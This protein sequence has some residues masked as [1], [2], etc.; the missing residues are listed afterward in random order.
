MKFIS[1]L[2]H[3]G[4]NTQADCVCMPCNRKRR[5]VQPEKP[6]KRVRPEIDNDQT[7]KLRSAQPEE[8][9]VPS[10]PS[11]PSMQNTN[12]LDHDTMQASNSAAVLDEAELDDDEEQEMD[13]QPQG[14]H[15][16]CC[17]L[18]LIQFAHNSC[19]SWLCVDISTSHALALLTQCANSV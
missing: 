2:W 1:V 10:V 11:V 6:P 8:P 17:S 3:L 14:A 12:G 16:F 4:L 18:W 9:T 7:R 15:L 5:K 13:S 19:P